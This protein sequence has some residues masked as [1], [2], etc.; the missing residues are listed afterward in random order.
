MNLAGEFVST[1]GQVGMLAQV[2]YYVL[3]VT[4]LAFFAAFVYFL[5][6]RSRVVAEHRSAMV[7]HAIICGVAGLSY[8]KIQDNFGH[9]LQVLAGAPQENRLALINQA[10]V[11]IGQTRYMDWTV[12]TPLLLLAAVLTLR[13]RTRQV[14]GPVIVMLLADVF[15]IVTGFIGDNQI[16][17]DGTILSGPRL[18]WGTISTVGYLAVVYILF[19]QFGKYQRAA[20]REESTAFW[21][22]RLATITT[23]GVY[24][25]GYLVPAFFANVDDN[26]LNVAFSVGDMLN[27]VGVGVVAFWAAATVYEKRHP[28]QDNAAAREEPQQA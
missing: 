20:H 23:W 1:A 26:W 16:A 28:S 2:T 7:T 4:A 21:V 15:M 9:F 24:P 5:T 8:F 19:S 22:A 3:L 6:A 11:A 18:L 13:V 25:L 14:L 10:Y 27:K 12:T 17:A